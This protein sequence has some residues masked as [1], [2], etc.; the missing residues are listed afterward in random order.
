MLFVMLAKIIEDIL[1][2]SGNK[3]DLKSSNE[4]D[5]MEDDAVYTTYN[6]EREY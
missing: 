6:I 5:V 4:A 3:E 2:I 1:Q